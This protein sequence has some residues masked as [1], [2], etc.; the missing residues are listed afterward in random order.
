MASFYNMKFILFLGTLLFAASLPAQNTAF[1]YQGRLT[2]QG[3]PASGTY[4]LQFGLWDSSSGPM[5]IVS[6]VTNSAVAISNGVFTVTLDFGNQFNNGPSRWLEIAVRTNGGGAFT[7]LSPR[8]QINPTPYAIYSSNSDIANAVSASGVS[9]VLAYYQLPPAL[10]TNNASGVNI[11]GAFNGNAGGLTNLN[12]TRIT[13]VVP[14]A[15]LS[16]NVALRAG[17]NVYS[18]SQQI[19][20]YVATGPQVLDQQMNTSTG[21]LQTYNPWQSF[22]AG[23]S[24]LLTAVA[25]EVDSP[26]GGGTSPG[27]IRIYAGEGTNGALLATQPVTWQDTHSTF[28]FNAF[29]T[30]PLLQAGSQYTISYIAPQVF[31]YWV[32]VDNGNHYAGG[33]CDLSATWDYAFRTYVTPAVGGQTILMANPIGASGYVGIGTNSPQAKL[34]VVGDI[35]ASGNV[36]GNMNATGLVSGTVSDARLS[37]NAAL[38]NRSI[39]AFTGGTNSFSGSVGIGTTT[40]QSKLQVAGDVKLGSSGQYFAPA[41]EENLRIVRGSVASNGTL[42]SGSGFTCSRTGNATYQVTF[43]TAFSSNP[44][45]VVSCGAPGAPAVNSQDVATL[46]GGSTTGFTVLIGVRNVGFFDEP[47]SFI[48]VGPR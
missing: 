33:R 40:P 31:W 6:P 15:V 19:V 43:T 11:S 26:L 8:Q 39:Q 9:G 12:A 22:T 17:G 30:P 2:V 46:T 10:I 3:A 41:G 1:T 13:G 44:S 37:G 45:V 5:I 47:F 27:T 36:F 35:L 18:G 42:L 29:T 16:T 21:V 48:A 32:Y 4:D 28:Q 38:L 20:D 14:D 25:L 34:H 7:T 24:G 23:T